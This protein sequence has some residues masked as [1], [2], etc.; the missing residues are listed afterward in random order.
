MR[1]RKR[2]DT[3]GENVSDDYVIRVHED[4]ADIAAAPWDALLDLQPEATPFMRHAYLLALHASGSAT[5]RTGWLPRFIAVEHAGELVAACALYLKSHSY[6]EDV[7]D[8]AWADAYQ[9]HGL[10]YYPQ[11]LRPVPLPPV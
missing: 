6:G 3:A 1:G 5:E 11:L 2:S 8:W 4:P 10:D 9:R 7:F